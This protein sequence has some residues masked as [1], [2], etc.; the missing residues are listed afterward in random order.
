[1]TNLFVVPTI[2]LKTLVD[3][4]LATISNPSTKVAYGY[5][6]RLFLK[7]GQPLTRTGVVTFVNSLEKPSMRTLCGMALRKLSHEAELAG[8]MTAEDERRIRD[9]RV[10]APVQTRLGQWLSIEGCQNLLLLPNKRLLRG[11]RDLAIFALTLGCGLRRAEC[12]AVTWE[13][14]R[15]IDGRAVLV[16]IWGKGD[17]IRS[18]PVP[19]WA[20]DAIDNWREMLIT[21]LRD[22]KFPMTAAQTGPILRGIWHIDPTRPIHSQAVGQAVSLYSKLLG[23]PFSCHD[24]RRTLAQ[25]MRKAGA[26]LEQIQYTLGHAGV[27]TTERYLGGKIEL[28]K[29]KAAVDLINWSKP[30]E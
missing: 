11:A 7:S 24:M 9:F 18:V 8:Y 12:V 2:N 28:G 27:K 1:M 13:Q 3:R 26:S 4:V 20:Q 22:L 30:K 15:I 29:G 10:K 14:Y 23:T 19:E 5:A 17:K 6:L 21:R 25:L 16:D